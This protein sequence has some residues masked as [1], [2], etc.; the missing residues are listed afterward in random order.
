SPA[1][2]TAPTIH[3]PVGDQFLADGVDVAERSVVIPAMN[4]CEIRA[5]FDG[6]D[7]RADGVIGPGTYA[8]RDTTIVRV[9]GFRDGIPVTPTTER[10][11]RRVDPR[12]A[13]SRTTL[14]GLI[15]E[16]WPGAFKEL[17]A[18]DDLGA[19]KRRDV[20]AIPAPGTPSEEY[21]ARR[22]GGWIDV[23]ADG[24]W[25]FEHVCD[26]G[27]RLAIDGVVVVDHD[28]LHNPEPK[29]G[30]VALSKGKHRFELVHF[31]ATGGEWLELRW[32]RGADAPS[33]IPSTA[34]GHDAA[35]QAEKTPP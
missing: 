27:G 6:R 11:I 14:P 3:G 10:T 31:N 21:V 2:F 18:F 5:T 16:S 13:T 19:P 32:A 33:P 25:T 7:P 28:G 34:F 29:S 23:P 4:G 30:R 22:F 8:L 12:A 15:R 17:P 1:V 20:V 9:R 24:V 26:D 35:K